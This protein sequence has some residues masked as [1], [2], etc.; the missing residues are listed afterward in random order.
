MKLA[1]MSGE[2]CGLDGNNT[3]IDSR[4]GAVTT[5]L[6]YACQ[7]LTSA[8]TYWPATREVRKSSGKGGSFAIVATNS[9]TTGT[10]VVGW[11]LAPVTGWAPTELYFRGYFMWPASADQG[12]FDLYFQDVNDTVRLSL[13]SNGTLNLYVRPSTTLSLQSSIPTFAEQNDNV[14][15]PVIIGIR[16]DATDG[17]VRIFDSFD[18]TTPLLE[19][20]GDT[21]N[22]GGVGYIESS[23]V[24]LTRKGGALDD[25]IY[26]D[27]SQR[28]TSAYG[29]D[30]SGFDLN[31]HD[32]TGAVASTG[33]ITVNTVALTAASINIGDQTLTG[34]S[35]ARTSGSNDFDMSGS[36]TAIAADIAAA[37]NDAN[38]TFQHI[39]TASPA[40][41][42]VTLTASV[43]GTERD[44]IV[45]SATSNPGASFTPASFSGGVNGIL[46]GIAR[47]DNYYIDPVTKDK[48][49]VIGISSL[50]DTNPTDWDGTKA[51][52]PLI[53]ATYVQRPGGG[54]SANT[55]TSDGGLDRDSGYPTDSFFAVP[56]VPDGAGTVTGLTPSAGTNW[57][58]VNAGVGSS[59]DASYNE[60]L[61]AGL[62]DLYTMT[63]SALTQ[64]DISE[65][66]SVTAYLR[67]DRDGVGLLNTSPSVRVG[68]TTYYGLHQGLPDT[69]DLVTYTW[70]VSPDTGS[71]W[72]IAEI[73]A[74]E[75]GVKF[76][77]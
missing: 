18:F 34:V 13:L 12:A 41:A 22:S 50:T 21:L 61:T 46:L 44:G 23:D 43:K 42:V 63:N 76:E 47:I 11:H 72:T 30:P 10:A 15:F 7:H 17:F 62:E 59:A 53:G 58:N 35:G 57:S 68:G 65:V 5:T 67:V 38:N 1:I 16:I 75:A 45:V 39:C 19:Y 20:T 32:D 52:D 40:G 6:L 73:N 28:I 8:G 2:V 29:P 48:R 4:E 70:D 51:N 64:P 77:E 26:Q 9:S 37:I 66:V 3:L 33:S 27:V 14:Y 55:N 24:V 36:T 54:W 25:V 60:G 56:L 74:I 49:G 71:A 31:W 69:F